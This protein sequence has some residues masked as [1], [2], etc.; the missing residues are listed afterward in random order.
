MAASQNDL[1][2]EYQKTLLDKGVDLSVKSTRQE[3]L[4]KFLKAHPDLN[5]KSATAAWSHLLPKTAK[6][7]GVDPDKVKGQSR[8]KARYD[9]KTLNAHLDAHPV[10]EPKDQ[11]GPNWRDG[12]QQQG[13]PPPNQQGQPPPG[14]FTPETVGA[15]FNGLHSTIR[16]MIPDAAPL[17]KSETDSLGGIW[18]HDFNKR[19]GGHENATTLLAIVATLGIFAANL[20]AGI[21]KGRERRDAEKQKKE[22][23]ESA[24]EA[25][26][27]FAKKEQAQASDNV[28][29]LVAD[30]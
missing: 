7:A 1:I 18:V 4:E 26:A 27:E 11:Q 23:R 14:S 28:A 8:V 3:Q 22:S 2:R 10:E 13:Q 29:D 12:K 17:Q 9:K 21:K 5:K 19:L 24:Q 16:L 20:H 25:A 15:F 6:A 30:R